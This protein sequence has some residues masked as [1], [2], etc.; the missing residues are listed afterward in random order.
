MLINVYGCVLSLVSRP[1]GKSHYYCHAFN[2]AAAVTNLRV[3][4]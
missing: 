3:K 4:T 2:I 1:P